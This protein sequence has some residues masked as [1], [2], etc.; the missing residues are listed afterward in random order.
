VSQQTFRSSQDDALRIVAGNHH[1]ADAG[2]AA[3]L[4]RRRHRRAQGIRK[5]DKAEERERKFVRR[6]RA[7]NSGAGTRMPFCA[8]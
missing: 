8:I 6:V 3:F 2:G 7:R 5:A 4:D 1:H